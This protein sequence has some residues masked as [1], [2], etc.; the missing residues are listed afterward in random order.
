MNLGFS[1][2]DIRGELKILARC[3]LAIEGYDVVSVLIESCI[4]SNLQN[5]SQGNLSLF[6]LF[7]AHKRLD[8]HQ[9]T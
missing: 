2:P 3:N 4:R 8:L 1:E 9:V 5:I 7:T 6:K